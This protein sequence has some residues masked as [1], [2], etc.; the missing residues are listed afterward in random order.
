MHPVGVLSQGRSFLAFLF[1][2]L[3]AFSGGAAL[4]RSTRH[5]RVSCSPLFPSE[6]A[7]LALQM[8]APYN[9]NVVVHTK[10]PA[11]TALATVWAGDEVTVI[12]QPGFKLVENGSPIVYSI[13]RGVST[14][15]NDG[16]WS[17]VFRCIK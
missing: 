7:P 8:E 15:Q 16:S 17:H 4:L 13:N 3:L 10:L 5:L 12:C 2:E 14:C 6:D 11:S 9:G 1:P